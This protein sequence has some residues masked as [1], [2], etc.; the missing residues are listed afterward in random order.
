MK[1]RARVLV[2]HELHAKCFELAGGSRVRARMLFEQ[3]VE[4]AIS[5]ETRRRS[6]LAR[7]GNSNLLNPRRR[8]GMV[9]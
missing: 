4:R 3:A 5:T 8:Y 6:A 2:S 7:A 9:W 1:D